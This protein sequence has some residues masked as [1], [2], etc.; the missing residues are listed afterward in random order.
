M[1]REKLCP[2]GATRELMGIIRLRNNGPETRKPVKQWIALSRP[3]T[4]R[5][6]CDRQSQRTMFAPSRLNKKREEIVEIVAELMR[7]ANTYTR[8]IKR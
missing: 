4:L 6:R 7:R 3:G 5:R 8:I 2:R 1:Y